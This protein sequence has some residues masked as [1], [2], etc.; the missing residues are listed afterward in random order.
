MIG[1][2][3]LFK[4]CFVF[5]DFFQEGRGVLQAYTATHYDSTYSLTEC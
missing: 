4:L 2:F 3:R 1:Q 5:F